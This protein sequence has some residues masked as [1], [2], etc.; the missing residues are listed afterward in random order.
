METAGRLYRVEE[1]AALL[2]RSY[3]TI[4]DEITSSQIRAVRVGARGVRVPE[5]EVHRLTG[6]QSKMASVISPAIADAP[7]GGAA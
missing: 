5:A 2:G 3:R 7:G 4:R 1:V 6:Q